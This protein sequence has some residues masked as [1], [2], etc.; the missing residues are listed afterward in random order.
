MEEEDEEE[1]EEE[2]EDCLTAVHISSDIFA[3]HQE[4]LNY[5]YSFWVYSRVSSAPH[6]SQQRHT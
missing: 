1:E 6:S 2:E 3:Y 5:N 4:H